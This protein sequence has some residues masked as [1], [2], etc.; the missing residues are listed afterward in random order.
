[1]NTIVTYSKFTVNAKV[2][3]ESINNEFHYKSS[4]NFD[5]QDLNEDSKVITHY[6]DYISNNRNLFVSY[7][8]TH[9]IKSSLISGKNTEKIQENIEKIDSLIL[10]GYCNSIE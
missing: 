1:M 5:M 10:E 8:I 6:G 7:E 3:D 2:D 4:N 9:K